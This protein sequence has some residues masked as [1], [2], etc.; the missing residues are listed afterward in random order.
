MLSFK[1]FL[2][3]EEMSRDETIKAMD[4]LSKTQD[5]DR[6]LSWSII[7][8]K[9]RIG[10]RLEIFDDC[11]DDEGNLFVPLGSCSSMLIHSKNIR[12]FKNF[13]EFIGVKQ[14]MGT[15]KVLN[16]TQDN[17]ISS[18]EGFPQTTEGDLNLRWLS[19][20]NFSKCNK[21]MET[22]N[23]TVAINDSYV[24]PILSFLLVKKLK[25]LDLAQ[26]PSD[27]ALVAEQIFNKHLRG[28]KEILEC[29]EELMNAGF[30]EYAKL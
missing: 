30:K 25:T 9:I 20:V 4:R 14:T 6:P 26:S 22:V 7:G 19:H 29:K 24:G 27:H 11:L 3:E 1:Q 13:P 16:F 18:L 28:D 15:M 5:E 2:L 23:G 10:S 17:K 8:N 21:F 12:S